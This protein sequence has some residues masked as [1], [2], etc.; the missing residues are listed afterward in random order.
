MDSFLTSPVWFV[1]FAVLIVLAVLV[2]VFASIR[3]SKHQEEEVEMGHPV[4]RD[5]YAVVDAMD[6]EEQAELLAHLQAKLAE[7]KE[8]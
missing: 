1:V 4:F 2:V 6:E 7:H 8:S 5:V 3:A